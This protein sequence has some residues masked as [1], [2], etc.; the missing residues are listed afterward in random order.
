MPDTIS[1]SLS[2]AEQVLIA[3]AKDCAYLIRKYRQGTPDALLTKAAEVLEQ[4]PD[5]VRRSHPPA[6]Q[7]REPMTDEQRAAILS[8]WRGRNWTAGDIIDAVEAQHN[9]KDG[10]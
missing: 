8:K 4:V 3:T 6:A 2:E 1:Q 7:D 5:L 10:T 9:I